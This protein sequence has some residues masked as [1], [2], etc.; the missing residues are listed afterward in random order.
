[1]QTI[2]ETPAYLAAADDAGMSQEERSEVADTIAA[3][4]QAG[5]VMAG[6]GGCR[7]LRVAGRGKGK[8]G[9][10]RVVT[11][12]GGS[13]VPVFLLT[14]FSKGE[15]ANLSKAERNALAL[16]IKTLVDSLSRKTA[17]RSR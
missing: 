3:N 6:T 12:F 10:Y 13:D 14:C 7:K 5:E 15:R 16:L 11:W 4:P 17:E 2:I 8:S 9:G 1:M